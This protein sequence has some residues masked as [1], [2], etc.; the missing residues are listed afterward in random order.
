MHIF[1]AKKSKT[2]RVITSVGF[3]QYR[4]F[5]MSW[6]SGYKHMYQSGINI[7]FYHVHVAMTM[8][9]NENNFQSNNSSTRKP[10]SIVNFKLT[11]Y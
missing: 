8:L 4:D 5:F 11:K 7:M 10:N 1:S 3:S 9:D 2:T 6:K